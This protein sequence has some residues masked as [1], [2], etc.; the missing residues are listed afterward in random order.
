M[1]LA[2]RS[3]RVMDCHTTT[4]GWI[5]GGN[6]VFTKLSAF[7]RDSKW[8]CR[9]QMTSLLKG[10]KTQTNINYIL[11]HSHTCDSEREKRFSG[12]LLTKYR[13]CH[14]DAAYITAYSCNHITISDPKYVRSHN[15]THSVIVNYL[16]IF[17]LIYNFRIIQLKL[18]RARV[19]IFDR[20]MTLQ[21]LGNIFKP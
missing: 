10:H 14:D 7:A 13:V 4:R 6:G 12:P 11:N 2:W 3:G 5:P 21:L 15:N 16:V 20:Q 9:L 18:V 17:S 8:G 1:E 19:S